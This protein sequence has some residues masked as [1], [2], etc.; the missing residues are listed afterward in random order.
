V[1]TST[2][3]ALAAILVA[4]LPALAVAARPGPPPGKYAREYAALNSPKWKRD[5]PRLG[6]FEVLAPSTP[7]E[8]KGV[9]NCIAYSLKIH[10]RWVNPAKSVAGFDRMYGAQGYRRVKGL[11][12]H[13]NPRL[14][15]VVVYAKKGRTGQLEYTHA[16]R[17]LTNGT[18]TSKLGHGPLISHATPD[19]LDG[20]SYGRPV[21]VYVKARRAPLN[22]ARPTS[23]ASPRPVR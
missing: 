10:D 18:W 13:F 19:S 1:K 6:K 15:K 3:L 16:C 23:V 7:G 14:E 5:F 22:S 8:G 20:P 4:A 9:Y 12:Y 17:Q 11:D 2:R 21:A